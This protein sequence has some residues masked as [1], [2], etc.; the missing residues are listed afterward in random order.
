MIHGL[1]LKCAF[2]DYVFLFHG[3]RSALFSFLILSVTNTLKGVLR[4]AF[5]ESVVGGKLLSE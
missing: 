2:A 1:A 4:E 3:I 5:G